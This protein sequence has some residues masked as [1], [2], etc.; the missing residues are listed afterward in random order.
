[1]PL[2]AG[3]PVRQAGSEPTA[4]AGSAEQTAT[5]AHPGSIAETHLENEG[6]GLRWETKVSDPSDVWEVQIDAATGR[7][8]S[9]HADD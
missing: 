2:P 3:S 9:S 1:M 4:A 8:A 6:S 7:V 5:A